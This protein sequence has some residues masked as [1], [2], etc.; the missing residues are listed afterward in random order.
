MTGLIDIM[1]FF[2]L[3]KSK[4]RICLPESRQYLAKQ[5]QDFPQPA[6][7]YLEQQLK[8][9]RYKPWSQV[10]QET[11]VWAET[12]KAPHQ[13]QILVQ[14]VYLMTLNDYTVEEI[15][16]YTYQLGDA[17]YLSRLEIDDLLRSWLS[18]DEEQYTHTASESQR[19][20]NVQQACQLLDLDQQY[21]SLDQ[22][23]QAYRKKMAE[24][25]PDKYPQL[26]PSVRQLI[27]QQAMQLNQARDYLK[28]YLG[29]Y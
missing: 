4:S 9:G 26:P 7:H 22:V 13:S 19:G 15:T 23:Q 2:A 14:V 10:R 11:T 20:M 1:V 12:L 16:E 17:L 28:D 25:H 29:V 6:K 8:Q 5:F 3:S 21:L 24:F 27:E 18:E